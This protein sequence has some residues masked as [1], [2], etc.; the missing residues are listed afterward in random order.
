MKLEKG[1]QP[2]GPPMTLGNMRRI[3]FNNLNVCA[4]G[5]GGGC[6][7]VAEWQSAGTIQTSKKE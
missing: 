7:G 4:D 5:A 2:A 6:A 1:K 3:A